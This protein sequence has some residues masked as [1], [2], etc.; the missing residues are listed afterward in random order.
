MQPYECRTEE[1]G[2]GPPTDANCNAPTRIDFF[3]R[4]TANEFKP[5]PKGRLPDDLKQTTTSEG[6]T[7]P[8]IVRVETGTVNRTIYRIATLGPIDI[9][10][11]AACKW[12]FSVLPVLTYRMYAALRVTEN[13]H[14]RL[15][16]N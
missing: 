1:A 12:H 15:A 14:F 10:P 8:Y 11:M 13:H 3:Y 7:L 9:Q 16:L 5:L 4:S 6:V 2:M